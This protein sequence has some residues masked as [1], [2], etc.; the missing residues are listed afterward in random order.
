M[1]QKESVHEY[2]AERC[3]PSWRIGTGPG[4]RGGKAQSCRF[5]DDCTDAAQAQEAKESALVRG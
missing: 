3:E 4:E 1:G 5:L 2:V